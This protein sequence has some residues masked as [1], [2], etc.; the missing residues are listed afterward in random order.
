MTQNSDVDPN[1]ASPE[2]EQPEEQPCAVAED[3]PP[4]P[5]EDSEAGGD[6]ARSAFA[7]FED[8][9]PEAHI[10]EEIPEGDVGGEL[11]N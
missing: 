3:A 5:P 2:N 10:G 1:I 7:D 11:S 8:D 4:I 6:I 9:D